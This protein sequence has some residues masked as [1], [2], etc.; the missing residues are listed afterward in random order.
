[1]GTG[2]ESE[3]ETVAAAETVTVTVTVTVTRMETEGRGGRGG[4]QPWNPPDQERRRVED[5]PLLFR[6][7]DHLSRP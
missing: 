7:R 3:T 6:T 1:M 4:I 2:T 5:H